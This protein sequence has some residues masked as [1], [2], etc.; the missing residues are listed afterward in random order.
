MRRILVVDPVSNT[1]ALIRSRYQQ[2]IADS[3]LLFLF[4]RNQAEALGLVD[5]EAVDVVLADI[6]PGAGE[7]GLKLLET[8]VLGHPLIPAIVLARPD[9]MA[10]IRHAMNHGAFDFLLQPPD[11]EDLAATL[12]RALRQVQLREAQEQLRRQKLA[13][14]DA[15]YTK[16]VFLTNMS[17]ELRTPLNAIIGYSEMLMEELEDVE[18]IVL[19]RVASDLERINSAGR[20]LLKL[21]DEILDLSRI[22]A[23]EMFLDVRTVSIGSLVTETAALVTP[24]LSQHQCSLGVECP[25]DAGEIVTDPTKLRQ[26][27]CNLL[28]FLALEAGQRGVVLEVHS[29]QASG[30]E[31]ILFTVRA[32]SG[33]QDA[34]SLERL[35]QPF[36]QPGS[37]IRQHPP[38]GVLRLSITRQLCRQMGGDLL[39]REAASEGASLVVRLPRRDRRR[40]D[41]DRRRNG[42]G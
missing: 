42:P 31:W 20:H 16:D 35:F 2:A 4:A 15:S 32:R 21:V 13:A 41:Q 12:D 5:R 30:L 39:V 14:E 8:L 10:R 24:E 17:H 19:P 26:C 38:G 36:M 27:L 18:E 3:E 6:N 23:G 9:D 11:P 1:Q 33:E 22:Q 40:R 37:A 28:D 29:E 34:E 25:A 7:D